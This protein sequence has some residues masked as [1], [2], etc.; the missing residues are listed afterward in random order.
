MFVLSFDLLYLDVRITLFVCMFCVILF[1]ND[2]VVLYRFTCVCLV[3]M[4]F[5]Y[6]MF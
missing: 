6:L 1:C 5:F 2:V 3:F 4:C